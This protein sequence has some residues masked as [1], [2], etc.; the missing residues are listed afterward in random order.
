MIGCQI[1]YFIGIINDSLISINFYSFIYLSEYSFFI[2][3]M[4]MACILLDN[5]VKLHKANEE[6]NINLENK[7]EQRTR[8]ILEAQKQVK[9]PEGIIP[10]CM[11]FKKDT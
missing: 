11:Y 1:V 3:I 5:F 9:Q 7:V 4:A 8:E 6:L 10:I 2:I